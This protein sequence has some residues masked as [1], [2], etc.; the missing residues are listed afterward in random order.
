M[1]EEYHFIGI[2]GVGMS[3][4]AHILLQ[5]GYTVSGSD[6]KK[7]FVTEDLERRGASI[8]Y[9]HSEKG[10][11]KGQIIVFNS[12]ISS[13]NPELL[14]AKKIGCRILHRSEL[15]QILMKGKKEIIVAGSHGKTTTSALLSY[16]LSESLENPS[17]VVGGF[18][19]SLKTNG[20]HGLGDFFI[21]EGDESDGSFLKT[22]PFGAIV[23]NIDFDHLSH[24]KTRQALLD[25]FQTFINQIRNPSFLIYNADDP[26]LSTM[27]KG[28]ISFGFSEKV[29]AK[30]F[31]LRYEN[32]KTLF[33]VAF[34]GKI[35]RDITI[36]LLGHHNILNALGVFCMARSLG[37][38]EASS[39]SALF[40]FQG[41]KRRLENR[42]EFKRIRFIDDYAHHPNEI[43]AILQTL[44]EIQE[45]RRVVIVFQPHRFSR[46]EELFQE[47]VDVLQ[48]ID[49]L[50]L[51]DI[52]PA[53]EKP[54]EGITAEALFERLDKTKNSTYLPKNQLVKIL[55][56]RLKPNDLLVTLGAGDIS[57]IGLELIKCVK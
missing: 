19:P 46:T 3:A 17:Y 1:S 52:Y 48:E 50:I 20:A 14:Q 2:G 13:Q 27:V 39:R 16:V 26:Y 25:G 31:K 10:V 15:L 47:F 45:D 56:E 21:A 41:V 34:Q 5:K 30:A 11:H 57:E 43:R 22:D 6:I 18:S 51:T 12:M 29:N 24:W 55:L 35:Y 8:C 49:V 40:S 28:G 42:G 53:G 54:I 23:T 4:L 44:R 33:D 32:G 37:L 9:S 7:T 36:S 38:A